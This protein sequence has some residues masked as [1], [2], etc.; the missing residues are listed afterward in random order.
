MTLVSGDWVEERAR[1][2]SELRRARRLEL[3]GQLAAGVAHDCNNLLTAIHGHGELILDRLELDDPL[4]G[5]LEEIARASARAAALTRQLLTFGTGADRPPGP[6]ALD[7]LV[8][9]VETLLRRMVGG[10]FELCVVLPEEPLVV[11]VDSA[12]IEQVL[13]NLVLNA[14]DAMPRGGVITVQTEAVELEADRDFGHASLPAGRYARLG[15]L[16]TGTGM[17]ADVLARAFELFFTTKERA[18][19]TGLGLAAAHAIAAQ[20]GGAVVLASEPGVGTAA[21]VYLPLRATLPPT[22]T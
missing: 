17:R 13:L 3:V 1:L 19:G 12:Q 8:R 9:G 6:V 2:E 22:R 21:S 5:D 4:R 16:D 15:V 7:G 14:R 10:E 11:E 18:Q 20:H